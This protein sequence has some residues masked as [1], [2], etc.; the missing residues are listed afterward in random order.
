MVWA[1]AVFGVLAAA[2]DLFILVGG[3]Q[4]SAATAVNGA[5]GALGSTGE[6][7]TQS[8][9]DAGSGDSSSDDSAGSSDSSSSSSSS[10]ASA[11]TDGTFTGSTITTPHGEVQVQLTV[12]GGKITTVTA[13]KYPD[14]EQ[15]SISI[16]QQSIPTLSNEAVSAQSANISMVSG[17]TETSEGF[18]NSLQDAINQA[19]QG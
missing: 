17:A 8:S 13:V 2:A 14:V 18:I 6:P 4:N 5:S 11:L 15:R 9:A 16:A 3:R 7:S 19:E 10:S 1:V 12:S